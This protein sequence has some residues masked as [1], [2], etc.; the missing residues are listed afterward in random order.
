[1]MK[2][3]KLS[4]SLI[5]LI[6]ACIA[7]AEAQQAEPHA[8]A[9]PKR[10][11]GAEPRRARAGPDCAE[12]NALSPAPDE[13]NEYVRSVP[14]LTR[15]A[16]A[17]DIEQVRGLLERGAVPNEKDLV[18]FTPLM[19]AAAA[20][21]L[22]VVRALLGAGADPNA[23]GGVAHVGSWSVLTMAMNR[24]NGKWTEVVDTLI[25][26]GAKVNPTA[27]PIPLNDAIGRRDLALIQAML[28]R[29]ADVN[30]HGGAP[31]RAAVAVAEPDVE[32]VKA[33]LAAGADPNLPRLN[34]GDKKLSLL[35]Y[36][37]QYI[38]G[39]RDGERDETDEAREKI[40]RLLKQA[41]AKR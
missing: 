5:A 39:S 30:L 15:A 7:V 9:A 12:R 6:L 19:V 13:G 25:K 26:A 24:C 38:E 22:D 3:I 2:N 29:G 35:A 11:A 36:L 18:G 33:L 32:I 37:K 8:A 14:R 17:G 27:G 16:A 4:F 34:V 31:L 1:M 23:A 10:V 28:E 41:G 21:H 40:V 20:G